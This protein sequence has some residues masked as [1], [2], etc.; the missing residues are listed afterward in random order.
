[1]VGRV[2]RTNAFRVRFR[3]RYSSPRVRSSEKILRV[4][5]TSIAWDDDD[6]LK[7]RYEKCKLQL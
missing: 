6:E 4:C 3:V 1:M 7:K 5:C 2:R